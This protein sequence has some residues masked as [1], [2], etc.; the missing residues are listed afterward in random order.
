MKIILFTLLCLILVG[1]TSY[2]Y[3]E[4]ITSF[5]KTTAPEVVFQSELRD[6]NG[7]LVAYLVTDRI[8]QKDFEHFDEI[9]RSTNRSMDISIVMRGQELFHLYE[10][11]TTLIQ[12][13]DKIIGA[14]QYYLMDKDDPSLIFNP[15][16]ARQNGIMVKEGYEVVTHWKIITPA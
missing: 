5:N 7:N 4:W 15:I 13:K 10:F 14:I 1:M 9:F 6:S 3:A 8:Y 12:D 2:S 16:V 11:E